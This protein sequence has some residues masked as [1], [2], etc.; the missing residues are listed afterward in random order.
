MPEGRRG[1]S[2]RL[3]THAVERPAGREHYAHF[4]AFLA[5]GGL[6]GLAARAGATVLREKRAVFRLMTLAVLD[7]A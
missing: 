1:L 3:I 7:R 5:G 6:L 2:G 4:R